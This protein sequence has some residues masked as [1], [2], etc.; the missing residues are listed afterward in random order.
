M[1]QQNCVLCQRDSVEDWFV[2]QSGTRSYSIVRCDACKSAYV[3][4]RP[5]PDDVEH[6]YADASYN[7]DHTRQGLY[8][9]S[10]SK[11]AARLFKSF[12]RFINGKVL[13]DIGAGAGVAS[14]EAIR[15]GFTVRACEPSPQCRKEFLE[16]NGFEPEPS[17]FDREY[18]EKN[19]QQVDAALLSHVLEHLPNPDQVLQNLCLVLKPKG[20]VMIAVPLFGSII[21]AVLGKRDFFITP[22]EHLTYFSYSGLAELLKRNG[23]SVESM[24]TSPKVNMLRYRHRLGLACYGVNLAAYGVLKLSEVINRS[25][26]LNVCARLA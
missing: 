24:F 10:G 8:W 5:T 25:I 22:P 17:F 26:V 3:W 15:Q 20:T 2:R 18:A 4:P 19:R 7:P 6:I 1:D 12:G 14:A 23:F 13:L 21:T 16:R 9:P 11:D